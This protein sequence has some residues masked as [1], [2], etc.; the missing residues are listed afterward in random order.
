MRPAFA[1]K[2][3][4]TLALAAVICVPTAANAATSARSDARA[5]ARTATA[6][7]TK[8]FVRYAAATTCTVYLNYPKPGVVANTTFTI[9]AGRHL[10]WRY[11]VDGEWALVSDPGRA[12]DAFPWWG[13]TRRDCIGRSVPQLDYPAGQPAP[14]R[15]QEGRSNVSPSGWR[16]VGFTLPPARIVEQRRLVTRNATLRDEANFVIGN[17]LPGWHV[18]VSDKSRSQGHWVYVFVPNAQR[19]GY[20]EAAA[21]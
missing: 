14:D 8:L 11:N 1:V 13:F 15:V 6:A 16:P 9:P 19:W 12:H 2:T 17:V 3:P 10:I 7:Q 4:V 20:M 5:V 21:L 18:H